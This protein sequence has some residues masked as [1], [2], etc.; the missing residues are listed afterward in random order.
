MDGMQPA[1]PLS[2]P[3]AAPTL[4]EREVHTWWVALNLPVETLAERAALLSPDEQAR[5]R[6]YI[7]E[8]DR[9]RYIAGRAFLRLLLGAYLGVEPAEIIFEYS[10]MSKPGL[11]AQT[12]QRSLQFN[13]TNSDNRGLAAVCWECPIGVDLERVHSMPDEDDFA[14]QFFCPA[15]EA[16]LRAQDGAAKRSAFFQL[17]TCKEALL[18]AMGDGLTRPIN[19]VEVALADEKARLVAIAG[20]PAPAAAWQLTLFQ[21]APDFQA[22]LAVACPHGAPPPRYVFHDAAGDFNPAQAGD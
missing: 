9:Q 12:G 7:F 20:D 5:A 4:G 13:F 17:W 11:K 18:K 3:A 21:P 8:R 6:R 19:E 16:L 10:L 1:A 15:E 14:R 2:L 22:A